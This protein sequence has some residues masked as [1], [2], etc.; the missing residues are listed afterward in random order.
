MS[1]D[2][3]PEI[4]ALSVKSDASTTS[5]PVFE[6]LRFRSRPKKTDQLTTDCQKRVW[7]IASIK[8]METVIE[9]YHKIL[10]L[11]KVSDLTLRRSFNL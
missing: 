6:R 4:D 8:R 3:D 7:M 9:G 1:D 11:P 2:S 5:D 10:L